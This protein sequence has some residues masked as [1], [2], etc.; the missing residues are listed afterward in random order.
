[1]N[2]NNIIE[3]YLSS[4]G[5][6]PVKKYKNYSMY[7]APYREDKNPSMMVS[8]KRFE[9]LALGL[10]GGLNKLKELMHDSPNIYIYRSADK[11]IDNKSSGSFRF[12]DSKEIGTNPI[13]TQY[14]ASRC[15]DI[16]IA[17]LY[18][19]EVY[20]TNGKKSYFAIGL[21]TIFKNNFAL[22]NIYFKGNLGSG[23]S[24]F[25]NGYLGQNLKIFEGMF[26]MLSYFQTF[27]NSKCELFR[28]DVLVLNSLSNI[29]KIKNYAS[30]YSSL[31]LFLDRDK[32]GVA[33]TQKVLAEYNHAE[34]FSEVYNGYVDMNDSLVGL[35][36]M[37]ESVK[38]QI[39]K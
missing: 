38:G 36:K 28:G 27:Q 14:L 19:R 1:M 35:Q 13:L 37:I 33:S 15:I 20:F 12:I 6:Y 10:A 25:Q 16:S 2:N 8:R 31:E 4:K 7:H 26:S 21:P 29:N 24:Y 17:K 30:S 11:I 3:D 34:D 9:D 23:V 18:C 39:L 32:S 22:R 5:I